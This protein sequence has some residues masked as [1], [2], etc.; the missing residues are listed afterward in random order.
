LLATAL[1]EAPRPM[2][3]G[4]AQD[5][6]Q[7]GGGAISDPFAW[8]QAL[9]PAAT[10]P[11]SA[12]G[13]RAGSRAGGSGASTPRSATPPLSPGCIGPGSARSSRSN[14]SA[15][16]GLSGRSAVSGRSRGGCSGGYPG[17]GGAAGPDGLSARSSHFTTPEPSARS[18]E[19][20]SAYD[21]SSSACASARNADLDFSP[22]TGATRRRHSAYTAALDAFAPVAPSATAA[23]ASSSASG[24]KTS[25][26]PTVEPRQVFSAAR[27]GKHKEVEA[28]LIAGFPPNHADEFGNSLFHVACQNGNKRI[29][30]LAIKYGGN[31]DAQNNKGN[32]GLHFL[33]AYG[34]PEVAEYFIEKGASSS[35]KNNVDKEPREGI[36]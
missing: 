1:F 7:H 11:L 4:Y 33:F 36:R 26:Q 12:Q 3:A 31:M 21:A 28:S 27:H 2:H 8:R 22:S 24:S 20:V 17:V 32:T 35:I 10:P 23:A 29:A 34:Y 25:A 16:S 13:S 30:K 6:H 9:S 5:M 14:V 15:R 18:S 19:F